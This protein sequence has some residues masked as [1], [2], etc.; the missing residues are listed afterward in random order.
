MWNRANIQFSLL[1]SVT[2]IQFVRSVMCG[3]ACAV[4]ACVVVACAC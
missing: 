4:V 3:V 2:A 1:R